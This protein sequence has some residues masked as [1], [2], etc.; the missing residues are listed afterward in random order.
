MNIIEIITKKKDRKELTDDEI[1]FVIDGYMKEE[2]KDYQ[3]SSLLMAIVLNGMTNQ[4]IFALT[5][6][7]LE[8][9]DK[10][11]LSDIENVVDKH[12]TGGVGDKT[13]LIVG[14]IVASCGGH[15][16]KMSGPGLGHTGG[17][18]DKLESI[19]GFN[20]NLSEEQFKYIIKEVGFSDIRPNNNMVP[21]D[22]KIY[23]LRDVTGTV[24]SIPL[25][26]S[27]IMSKKIASGSKKIVIDVKVGKGALIKNIEDARNLAKI[28]IEIGKNNGIKVICLL[29]NMEMPLGDKI[30][31]SLEVEEAI[32]VLKNEKNGPLKELCIELSAYMVSLALNI[33]Y[34]EAKIKI[35]NNLNNGKA[36]KKF[37][38]FIKAQ[39]GNIE[40]LPKSKYAI[41]IKSKTEGYITDIDALKL[42]LASMKIGAGR[43]NK[44]DNIDYSAGI[45]I[46]KKIND[47]VKIGDTLLTIHSNKDLKSIENIDFNAFEVSRNPKEIESIILEIIK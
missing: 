18:I 10:L 32:E 31:N 47:Y 8:T 25:I 9:G 23:A 15:V 13:T 24:E 41:E 39:G 4:E 38:E 16:A 27:S 22:K 46:N 21:A 12:S 5:K 40:N 17:T 44:E 3:M 20:S 6:Y 11:D 42:G 14:P 1:K 29:T 26:A 45:V 36:Y 43:I 28:M 2:I 7:M 30:G 33:T 35:I 34:E 37:I 19:P